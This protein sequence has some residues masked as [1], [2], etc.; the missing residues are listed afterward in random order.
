MEDQSNTHY[1][2]CLSLGLPFFILAYE[3]SFIFL[4]SF[5]FLLLA[6]CLTLLSFIP[7]KCLAHFLDISFSLSPLRLSCSR[8][9]NARNTERIVPQFRHRRSETPSSL[10][11]EL[12]VMWGHPS[13]H[14]GSNTVLCCVECEVAVRTQPATGCTLSNDWRVKSVNLSFWFSTHLD[15]VLFELSCFL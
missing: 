15:L 1:S 2:L 13:L 4:S 6:F 7:L 11:P 3:L 8:V 9:S 10:P 5:L 12:R 14:C